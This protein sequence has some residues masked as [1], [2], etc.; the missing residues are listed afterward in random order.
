[1]AINL[2]VS[3]ER[4]TYVQKVGHFIIILNLINTVLKDNFKR[5]KEAHIKRVEQQIFL[6]KRIN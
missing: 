4:K 2:T 5:R 6:H 3:V 1:M